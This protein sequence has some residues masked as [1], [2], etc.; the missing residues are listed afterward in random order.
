MVELKPMSGVWPTVEFSDRVSVAKC[1]FGAVLE[2]DRLVM[3][4]R[5]REIFKRL[6]VTNALQ[7]IGFASWN[8]GAICAG[9]GEGWSI[10]DVLRANDELKLAIR[11]RFP[12]LPAFECTEDDER[13]YGA[14]DPRGR[15]GR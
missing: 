4:L 10:Q 1:R 2:Q 6:R 15:E 11:Q 5:F 3:P 13:P 8:P 9:L 14:I 12:G 7:F